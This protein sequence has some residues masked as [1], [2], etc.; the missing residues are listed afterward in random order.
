MDG[1]RKTADESRSGKLTQEEAAIL[2]SCKERA[3]WISPKYSKS[4][5]MPLDTKLAAENRCIAVLPGSPEVESYKMIRTQILNKTSAKGWNTLMITSAL[6]DEGK[7]TTAINL[8]MTFARE[9]DRTVLLVDCDFIRQNVHELL[10]IKSEKSLIDYLLDDSPITELLI[11]PGIEK[12]TLISGER[13]VYDSSELLGS[14]RMKELFKE[15]KTRYCDRMVFFDVPP[16]LSSADALTFAS[17]VD[18]I[19][20]VVQAGK[21]QLNDVRKALEMIPENKLVGLI[22]NRQEKMATKY[23]VKQYR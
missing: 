12:F 22:L 14:P 20:L 13:T 11:W 17:L 3:G 6:P 2:A 9:F 8:S 16:L 23:Y 7:T 21:T 19:I 15:L 5:S 18:G 4:I 1:I 10:G